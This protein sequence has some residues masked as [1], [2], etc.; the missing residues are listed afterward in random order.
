[1]FIYLVVIPEIGLAVDG[2]QD[3]GKDGKCEKEL[4]FLFYIKTEKYF[5][6]LKSGQISTNTIQRNMKYTR[7]PI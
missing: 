5:H 3:D 7:K 6:T 4:H 2:S 1:M